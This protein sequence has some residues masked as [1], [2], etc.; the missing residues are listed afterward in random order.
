M[1]ETTNQTQDPN[2]TE[3]QA[4]NPTG[5]DNAKAQKA[6]DAQQEKLRQAQIAADQQQA[7]AA[8]DANKRTGLI[9]GPPAPTSA[10]V[11]D[12]SEAIQEHIQQAK[13][14]FAE[15]DTAVQDSPAAEHGGIK[16]L[17]ARMRDRFDNLTRHAAHNVNVAK[18]VPAAPEAPIGGITAAALASRPTSDAHLNRGNG[19]AVTGN[20]GASFSQASAAQVAV[21]QGADIPGVA[22]IPQPDAA[23]R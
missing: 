19:G 5:A 4:P 3:N 22:K 21:D 8:V 7:A 17:L 15:L 10:E 6:L 11:A 12:N 2:K 9:A 14:E 18:A 1:D 13:S 23:V 20:P 16:G